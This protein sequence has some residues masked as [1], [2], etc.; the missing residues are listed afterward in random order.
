MCKVR[1][2]IQ[3]YTLYLKVGTCRKGWSDRNRSLEVSQPVSKGLLMLII[4]SHIVI[5]VLL[6]EIELESSA[7]TFRLALGY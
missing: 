5:S 2:H 6:S 7:G 3:F 4:G 1:T